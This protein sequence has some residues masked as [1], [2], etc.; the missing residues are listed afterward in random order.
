M[1]FA[2]FGV[3]AVGGYFGGRLAQAGEDVTFIAR[4]DHLKVLKTKGLRLDS[5]KGDVILSPVR[6]IDDPVKVGVVDVVL[7]GIKTWQVPAAAKA[8]Q[9]LIGED[10]IVL[11]LQ[12]GVEA[13]SQLSEVLGSG[14]V[15]GGLAK[16]VC[17]LADPGH[18][19]HTGMDPYIGFGE[20]NNRRTKRV[21]KLLGTLKNAGINAEI[22]PDITAALWQK[23]LFVVSWG[24][25]GAITRAPI[26]VIRTIPQ[27]RRLLAQSM[28]EILDVAQAYQIRLPADIVSTTLDFMDTLPPNGTTSMQRDIAEGRPSEIEAWNGAVVRLGGEAGVAVSLHAFIYDSLLPLEKKARGDLQFPI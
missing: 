20:L 23:F 21:E 18:I 12:N 5:V 1:R 14:N 26:G 22:M 25:V 10:T 19:R 3:G 9:P 13:A 15:C 17:F 2:I 16:I 27:T 8:I 6:V 11:P 24:G 28:R 7:V 4:G